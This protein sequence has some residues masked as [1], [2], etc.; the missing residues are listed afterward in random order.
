M[1]IGNI[2]TNCV[3]DTF[4]KKGITKP[5]ISDHFSIFAVIKLSNKKTKNRKIKIKKRF[6]SDNNKENFKQDLQKVNWG[7]LNILNGTNTLYS[8]I[9]SNIYEKKLK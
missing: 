2:F 7:K 3:F 1:L 8:S 5:S 4:L 6:F 9:Y